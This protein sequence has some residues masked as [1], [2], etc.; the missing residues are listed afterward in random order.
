M[1]KYL[2]HLMQKWQVHKLACELFIK[3]LQSICYCF[4]SSFKIFKQNLLTAPCHG[5]KTKILC[6]NQLWKVQQKSKHI[7][8]LWVTKYFIKTRLALEGHSKWLNQLG[9]VHPASAKWRI[10]QI[11]LWTHFAGHHFCFL[12]QLVD[13]KK[14]CVLTQVLLVRQ[15]NSLKSRHS[16]TTL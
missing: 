12:L 4:I 15:K 10:N 7:N 16:D 1:V 9:I 11:T 5:L 3:P 2:S 8:H 13:T 6:L 14:S